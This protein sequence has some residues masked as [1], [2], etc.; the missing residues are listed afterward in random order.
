NLCNNAKCG[1]KLP[2]KYVE[3]ARSGNL[4]CLG[5][6]GLPSHGKTALLSSLMQSAM[7]VH[8]IVPGSFVRP[9][10]DDTQKKLGEWSARYRSGQVKPPATPPNERPKPLLVMNNKFATKHSTIL[11]AYDLAGEVL[12]RAGTQPEYVRALNK[13]NTIWCVVSLD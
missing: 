3:N 10:D 11:V 6:F 1:Q 13:V 9:L 5:T 4:T 8:K 7:A 2:P 12:K